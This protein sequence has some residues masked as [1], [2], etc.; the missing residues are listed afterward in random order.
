MNTV[1]YSTYCHG[2]SFG[3]GIT[4]F[5]VSTLPSYIVFSSYL[6]YSKLRGWNQVNAVANSTD[7]HGRISIHTS[8]LA[9]RMRYSSKINKSETHVN[10][11]DV[12][13][14]FP[15]AFMTRVTL[16]SAKWCHEDVSHPCIH[17][18]RFCL[19]PIKNLTVFVPLSYKSMT[20][21]RHL[22]VE[23]NWVF[24]VFFSTLIW[25]WYSVLFHILDTWYCNF[26]SWISVNTQFV[27]FCWNL[28]WSD[29]CLPSL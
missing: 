29:P 17:V 12:D 21:M 19:P 5:L 1:A 22:N 27:W 2:R 18:T 8:M 26:N 15:P 13:E 7:Q 14:I 20:Y 6:T 16:Y 23:D 25:L 10:R 3:H 4:S 28:C 11:A 24:T 9:S